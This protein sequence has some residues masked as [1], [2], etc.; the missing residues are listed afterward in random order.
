MPALQEAFQLL[1]KKQIDEALDKINTVLQTA[2][3]NPSAYAL[4]GGVYA[5]KKQWDLAEK[6]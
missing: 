4:R 5:E 3:K 6:D 1:Q 2:P